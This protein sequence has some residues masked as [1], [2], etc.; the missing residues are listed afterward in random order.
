MINVINQKIHYKIQIKI[1]NNLFKDK[2]LCKKKLW[3]K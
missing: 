1:M 3:D 2:T